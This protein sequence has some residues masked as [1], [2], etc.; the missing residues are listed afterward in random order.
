M[1]VAVCQNGHSHQQTGSDLSRKTSHTTRLFRSVVGQGTD[2][3]LARAFRHAL[4][5]GVV[6]PEVNKCAAALVDRLSVAPT[7]C[8]C[9]Q[10]VSKGSSCDM[11]H[12][13]SHGYS[14]Y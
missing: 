1:C 4:R 2:V 11:G 7:S 13:C 5:D 3:G 9:C 12:W 14:T 6:R 8:C 10:R